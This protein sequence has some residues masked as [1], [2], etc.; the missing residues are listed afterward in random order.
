MSILP[1]S[2]LVVLISWCRESRLQRVSEWPVAFGGGTTSVCKF[3][4]AIISILHVPFSLQPPLEDAVMSR[5]QSTIYNQAAMRNLIN[6]LKFLQAPQLEAAIG[7][8]SRLIL[9]SNYFVQQFIQFNGLAAINSHNLL[10]ETHSPAILVDVLLILSQLARLSKEYYEA[11]GQS[12]FLPAVRPLLTH[13]DPNVRAKA[14]NLLGNLSRHSAYFYPL[15]LEHDVLLPLLQCCGDSDSNTRKFACFALGNAAFHNDS[16]YPHLKGCLP[17][18]VKLLSDPDEK[19]RANAAGAIG[20][21]A[22]N[23]DVLVTD[24]IEA[25]AIQKL[26]HCIREED[27]QARKLALFS[28]GNLCNFAPCRH[29]LRNLNCVP[30]LQ[31][32]AARSNDEQ[33]QKYVTR[34]IRHIQ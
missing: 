18:L 29:V 24:I 11:M 2:F 10:S 13:P 27:K 23:S 15:L 3:V 34:I 12:G 21:L 32:A 26:L 7:L 1:D 31:Q 17:L 25:Q 4:Q 20:N 14:C 5:F 19:T 33:I 6:C 22:R 9:G 16:L 30:I 28:L 8:L